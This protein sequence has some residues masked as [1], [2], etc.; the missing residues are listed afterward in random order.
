MAFQM[1]YVRFYVFPGQFW[2]VLYSSVNE[3]QQKW[4]ASSREEYIPEIL[5]VL[6]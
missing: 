5:T 3:L 1:Q 4:N 6:L 2:E